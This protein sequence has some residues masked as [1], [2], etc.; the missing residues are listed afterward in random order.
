MTVNYSKSIVLERLTPWLIDER[1]GVTGATQVVSSLV[2]IIIYNKAFSQHPQEN[3]S[4]L[5]QPLSE[6]YPNISTAVGSPPPKAL[7]YHANSGSE[8]VSFIFISEH[9]IPY[10][11]HNFSLSSV[12]H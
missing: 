7:Y 11:Y 6:I 2:L 10:K 8:V 5:N 4:N 3:P 9:I 12:K 1:L